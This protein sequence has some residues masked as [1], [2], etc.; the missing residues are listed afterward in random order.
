MAL[1]CSLLGHDYGE[2]QVERE[3]DERG[4]EVVVTV[5]EYERCTR[6]GIRNVLGENTEV[7]TLAPAT[8]DGVDAPTEDAVDAATP[9]DEDGNPIVDDAEILDADDEP[10]HGRRRGEWPDSQDVGPPVDHEREP[11]AWPE[12]EGDGASGSASDASAGSTE[13]AVF[14]DGPETAVGRTEPET[15]IERAGVAPTPGETAPRDGTQTEFFCPHCT[16]VAP[17]DRG[18]LRPGDICPECKRGYL[19]ERER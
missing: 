8:A 7:T 1:R 2:S 9:T 5:R 6:C 14:A 17:S 19:G 10:E 12:S 15:G 13:D 11:Q 18:S 3:R 4:S 16:F